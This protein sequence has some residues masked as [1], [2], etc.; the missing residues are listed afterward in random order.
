MPNVDKFRRDT[1]KRM[2]FERPTNHYD[3]SIHLVD[4]QLCELLKKRKVT[5]SNNPGFPPL[6]YISDW[7]KKYELHE[8]LLKSL[9]GILL[10]EEHF[11][12][13]VEPNGYRM[14]LPV[15]KS[16]EKD[17]RF[18][19]VTYIRQYDNASVVNF[20]IDWDASNDPPI[21]R[22]HRSFFKLFIGQQYDCRMAGGS[23]S[24]GHFTNDYIVSP[25]LP[26]N[27]SG[28]D[29]AFR[30]YNTPSLTKPTDFE[31]VIHID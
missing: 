7:A 14:H 29:L 28:L 15:L 27:I 11:R 18:F 31:F 1:M 4:E 22:P 9:F 12:P 16:F 2:I 3:E 20:N 24:T 13:M 25:P 30:E 21:D 5:S 10:N 23:G 17:N 6:E 19:S 8:D 26:D